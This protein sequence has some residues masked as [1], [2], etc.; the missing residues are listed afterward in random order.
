VLARIDEGLAGERRVTV[1]GG[2][3]VDAGELP[4]T[5]PA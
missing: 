2:R 4:R 5:R 1:E 3:A